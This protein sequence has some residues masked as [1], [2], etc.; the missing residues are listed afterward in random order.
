MAFSVLVRQGPAAWLA[1]ERYSNLASELAFLRHRTQ[2][3]FTS[4]ERAALL[5]GQIQQ[6]MAMERQRFQGGI[7]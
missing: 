7:V 2:R 6:R 4:P 5:E 3:G 1:C